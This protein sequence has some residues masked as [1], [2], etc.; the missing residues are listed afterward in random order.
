MVDFS[1]RIC[2]KFFGTNQRTRTYTPD[3]QRCK[4]VRWRVTQ[5]AR[6]VSTEKMDQRGAQ[7]KSKSS[8]K[9][10]RDSRGQ[11]ISELSPHQHRLEDS[12]CLDPETGRDTEPRALDRGL[13][14]VEDGSLQEPQHPLPSVAE[15]QEQHHDGLP[16]SSLSEAMGMPALQE[17]LPHHPGDLPG[18]PNLGLLRQQEHKVT[19]QVHDM[20]SRPGGSSQGRNDSQVGPDILPLPSSSYDHESSPEGETRGNTSCSYRAGMAVSVV[21]ANPSR[22]AKGARDEAALLQGRDLHGVQELGAPLPEPADSSSHPGVD[23]ELADFLSNHLATGTLKGYRGSFSK[24]SRYCADRGENPKNCSPDFIAS[25]L[26]Y[27]HDSG[28]QYSTIN[29]ARSAIS[30]F[31]DGFNGTQAGCNKLVSMAVKAVFKLNP[32]LPRYSSTFDPS[33]VLNYLKN[34]PSNSELDL[35]LL[36]QKALFLLITSSICRVNSARLLGPQLLVYKVRVIY[37][38]SPTLH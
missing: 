1:R 38:K 19:A 15:H 32:P 25:Y 31:H 17:N 24:F 10:P 21:V 29:H 13:L 12:S 8:Y 11:G 5:L 22:L 26:K 36:S 7:V 3:L 14:A 18:D 6:R 23:P 37:F 16:Q 9:L 28:S 35:K 30:K 4:P 27:L 33:L 2:S 20:V 34:L